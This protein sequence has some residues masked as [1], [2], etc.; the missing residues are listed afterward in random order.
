MKQLS[1]EEAQCRYSI[2]S[3]LLFKRVS[4]LNYHKELRFKDSFIYMILLPYLTR[5][6]ILKMTA[7]ETTH[8]GQ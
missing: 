5:G 6:C 3:G 8:T 7:K 1:Q 2:L 4:T